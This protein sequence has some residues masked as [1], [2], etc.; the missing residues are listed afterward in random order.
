MR[1]TRNA[2]LPW[3]V[4]PEV[5]LLAILMRLA[6]QPLSLW[7]R[8]PR[9]FLFKIRTGPCSLDRAKRRDA[10]GSVWSQPV[11]VFEIIHLGSRRPLETLWVARSRS[12]WEKLWGGL[13]QAVKPGCSEQYKVVRVSL[14]ACRYMFCNVGIDPGQAPST[15]LI[16]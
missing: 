8:R 3:N 2:R 7:D 15:C 4:N 1:A 5:L 6:F 12:I 10:V 9:P 13:G 11:W 16:Q 14:D